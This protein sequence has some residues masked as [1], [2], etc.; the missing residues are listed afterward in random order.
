VERRHGFL[1]VALLFLAGGAGGML[2]AASAESAP[3]ATGGNGAALALLAAWA[4]PDLRD[5]RRGGEVEG[6][7][8]GVAV[9]AAVVLLM[10]LPI[11]DADWLAGIT[12]LVVGLGLGLPLA[13]FG[14]YR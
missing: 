4:V 11:D 2:V 1:V 6:D 9:I 12:G 13:R 7:L 5:L 3:I 8:I 14:K 10:P